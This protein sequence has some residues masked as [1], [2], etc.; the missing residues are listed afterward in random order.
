MFRDLHVGVEAPIIGVVGQLQFEVLEYRLREEY[1]VNVNIQHL[2]FEI[3][4]WVEKDEKTVKLLTESSMSTV[5]MD[6]DDNYAVL[7]LD[8]WKANWLSERYEI[9]F[10][11]QPF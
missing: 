10:Y 1:G 2:P 4:R 11:N 7:L 8:Q 3:V 5:V 9:K 6:K